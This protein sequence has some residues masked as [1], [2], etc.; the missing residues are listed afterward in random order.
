MPATV[1]SLASRR[2]GQPDGIV[3]LQRQDA[4]ARLRQRV[5]PG[6]I[7][8]TVLRHYNAA[9][10]WLICDFYLIDGH[11]VGCITTDVARALERYDPERE[12]GVKI[13][14]PIGRDVL[15]DLIDGTLSRL[16]FGAADEIRHQ[17]I[18]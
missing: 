17:V 6:D 2:A 15:C 1:I 8:Y 5:R 3:Q 10:D 18:R 13:A 4:L 7:L 9:N 16:L 12:V 14:R 11:H